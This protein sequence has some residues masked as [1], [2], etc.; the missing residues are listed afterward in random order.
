[1][2]IAGDSRYEFLADP[3]KP[4]VALPMGSIILLGTGKHQAV[5]NDSQ[6]GLL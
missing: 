6:G 1:M 5:A 3:K 4:F 2:P